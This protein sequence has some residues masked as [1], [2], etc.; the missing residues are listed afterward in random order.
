MRVS[1]FGLANP[2]FKKN[3]DSSAF[4]AIFDYTGS[5]GRTST[6]PRPENE[7]V[8]SAMAVGRELLLVELVLDHRFDDRLENFAGDC[9]QRF[10]IHLGQ[11]LGHDL[12][13]VRCCYR[14]RRALSAH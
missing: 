1:G 2:E 3:V 13:H 11:Y 6:R 4:S 9:L 14:S 8:F 7:N 5:N 12:I 10:G